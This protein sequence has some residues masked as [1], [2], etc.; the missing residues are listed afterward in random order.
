MLCSLD[1]IIHYH[2]RHP[3]RPRSKQEGACT[4][5]C[6]HVF[7]RSIDVVAWPVQRKFSRCRKV[8]KSCNEHRDLFK[9][10]SL[11]LNFFTRYKSSTLRALALNNTTFPKTER[12]LQEFILTHYCAYKQFQFIYISFII[13]KGDDAF[14]STQMLPTKIPSH[15]INKLSVYT[16]KWVR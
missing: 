11:A 2:N 16:R 1:P 8:Q 7:P 4:A 3:R 13:H 9:N 6:Q 15:G 5:A 12:V 10:A 14:C